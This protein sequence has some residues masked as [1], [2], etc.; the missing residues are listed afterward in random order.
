MVSCVLKMHGASQLQR[1]KQH[2]LA[3]L[4]MRLPLYTLAAG[5][6]ID[7]SPS[8]QW[9]MTLPASSEHGGKGRLEELNRRPTTARPRGRPTRLTQ[10]EKK[11]NMNMKQTRFFAKAKKVAYFSPLH[12]WYCSVFIMTL[13]LIEN[14][15]AVV[16]PE[17]PV[18]YVKE[19]RCSFNPCFYLS[20]WATLPLCKHH[21]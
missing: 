15:P 21:F 4:Q 20:L 6:R 5:R 1:L 11:W 14:K 19:Y 16:V 9:D 18:T 7:S 10:E 13:T 12:I 3:R 2:W 17:S 8:V